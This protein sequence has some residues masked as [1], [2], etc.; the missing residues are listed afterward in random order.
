[1]A[2]PKLDIS[3]DEVQKLASIGCTTSEIA[4][5][6][7]CHRDTIEGRF[8]AAFHKG[9]ENGKTRLRRWQLQSAERGNVAMLIWLG[10][11]MLGQSDKHEVDNNFSP[12]IIKI[13]SDDDGL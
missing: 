6:F 3:E 4:A 9:R 2:R 10:K 8:S 1:M 11:Q 12:V 13:D 7:D 5:F